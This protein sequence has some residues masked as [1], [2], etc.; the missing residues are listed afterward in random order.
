MTTSGVR[1]RPA[2]QNDCRIRLFMSRRLSLSIALDEIRWKRE[3]IPGPDV[4]PIKITGGCIRAAGEVHTIFRNVPMCLILRHLP[5]A[6]FRE[7]P[8]EELNFFASAEADVFRD[9]WSK[10]ALFDETTSGA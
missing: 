3:R 7:I 4:W 1:A 5:V 2:G 8:S 6:R 9:E 10:S